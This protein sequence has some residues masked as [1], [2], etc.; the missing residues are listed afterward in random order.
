MN[1]A[2][3]SSAELAS[4]AIIAIESVR[5][6]ATVLSATRNIAVPTAASATPR[7]SWPCSVTVRDKGEVVAVMGY[8]RSV[9]QGLSA[10]SR[11]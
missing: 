3:T 9:R 10:P 6:K 4:E 11:R 8:R 1:E 2:N 7:I 5:M